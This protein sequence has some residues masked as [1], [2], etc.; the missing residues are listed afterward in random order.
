MSTLAVPG[1]DNLPAIDPNLSNLINNKKVPYSQFVIDEQ[2][3]VQLGKALFWDMQ[4]GSDGVQACA[5]C[6]FAAGIDSRSLNQLNPGLNGGDTSYQLGGPNYQL[7]AGDYPFHKLADPAD[8]A[9]AVQHD[10]NEVASSQGIAGSIFNDIV[11]G[12]GVDDITTIANDA[13]FNNGSWNTRRVEPR[14]TPSTVNAVF[15]FRNFWDGRASNNFNGVNPFGN[16]DTQAMVVKAQGTN[17]RATKVLLMLSSL[18]SQAVGPVLS[19]FEMSAA[20]RNWGKVGKKLLDP[21]LVPL[22]G[23]IVDP[24]DPFLGS[25]SNGPGQPGL[26]TTYADMVKAA[27]N[28]QW[29]N[30]ARII[31]FR[32]ASNGTLIPVVGKSGTPANS[33][34]FTVMEA[35]FSLF[36][37]LAVQ[38]Y[39][40]EL[41]SDQTPFDAFAGGNLNALTAQQQRGLNIFL[42]VGLD[43]TVP[44][45]ACIVCHAGSVFTSATTNQIGLVLD[46]PPAPPEA[47]FE[48][49]QA[50]FGAA[51][52]TLL[53][54]AGPVP[55]P[56]PG[57]VIIP[58][59]F[60]PRGTF[61]EVTN[62]GTTDVLF[63][64]LMP[65]TPQPFPQTGVC[66]TDAQALV[67]TASPLVTAVGATAAADFTLTADCAYEFATTIDLLPVG[68]Y[69]LYVD[70]ALMGTMQ[71]VPPVIYD[72]GFYN[73]GVRPTA[74]DIGI[75]GKDPFG[76]PLSFSDMELLQPGRRDTR[77]GVPGGGIGGG[78]ELN[79]PAGALGEGM[80]SPG[81]FKTPT[82]R[83]VELTAPYFHNGGQ[84]NLTQVVEFYNRGGDFAAANLAT[85]DADIAPIGMTSQ[86]IADLVA[87]LRSL[88]DERVRNQAAP[89]DHPQLFIPNGHSDID[90]ITLLAELP[91]VG[92]AGGSPITT[93]LSTNGPALAMA[94]TAPNVGRD[95]PALASV[96][97][98][99]A[100]ELRVATNDDAVPATFDLSQNYPNPFN[101]STTIRF[102]LAKPIDVTLEVYNLL[103]QRVRTLVQDQL[104]A[105]IHAITW[106]GTGDDGREVASGSYIYRISTPN[107]TSSRTMV[108]AK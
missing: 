86:D 108:F 76:N 103:G 46:A 74:E 9:S 44:V 35:N 7:K 15:N 23:Q 56:P 101:P 77:V 38:A 84:L 43:P 66:T 19:D 100:G 91:A 51:L 59:T 80:D 79:P 30:S 16:R 89:F 5:S 50:A 29:W 82:L 97:E 96:S 83:N 32:T 62:S 31:T 72:L 48:R 37:G 34:Q 68:F 10:Y 61:L 45:G 93:F 63:S 41:V 20:G 67:M 52:A 49:M 92:A 1:P 57:E 71:Q 55:P 22:A 98:D 4:V 21:N 36:F 94:G 6:H 13:P 28:A 33:D 25:L 11:P 39:E 90:G 85:L 47:I 27:F 54:T 81:A 88:T 102:S 18:A 12:S 69:D 26:N 105:G 3:L 8:A 78:F 40:Q 24:T 95:A 75:G 60:D 2:A 17:A 42:N 104:D 64:G 87:F 70:G 73:I 107:F 65:G 53:F 14:N 99:T 58:L 106:D